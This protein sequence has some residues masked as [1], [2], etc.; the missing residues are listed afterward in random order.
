MQSCFAA[1]QVQLSPVKQQGATGGM[2]LK[3]FLCKFEAQILQNVFCVKNFLPM[4]IAELCYGRTACDVLERV[5]LGGAF[6]V[7]SEAVKRTD[8]KVTSS[9]LALEPT[10]QDGGEVTQSA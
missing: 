10:Y 2:R 6:H 7:R 8:E 3:S 4:G 9:A 5:G 1:G